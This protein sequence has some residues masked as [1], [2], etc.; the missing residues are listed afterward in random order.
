M[1]EYKGYVGRVVFDQD[2]RL[3]HGEIVGIRD[4]VTFQGASV[5]ELEKAF[6]DSVDDY[7]NFCRER[8]ERPDKPCSGRFV[9]RIPPELHRRVA[10]LAGASGKSLNAWV[11]ERLDK[12][13][14]T[15]MRAPRPVRSKAGAGT[16]RRRRPR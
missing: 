14:E 13:A 8:G 10:M 5:D 11:A 2:A 4:V 6:K 9:V 16:K 12:E 15:E 7:L 1:M 3:F